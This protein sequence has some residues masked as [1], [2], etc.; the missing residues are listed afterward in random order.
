MRKAAI[1]P[2]CLL[3]EKDQTDTGKP[4]SQL[5]NDPWLGTRSATQRCMR[6]G[7]LEAPLWQQ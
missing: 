2:D 3:S 4:D 5:E 1:V 7:W 6:Q